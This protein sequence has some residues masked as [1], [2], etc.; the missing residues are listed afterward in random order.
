MLADNNTREKIIS[1]VIGTNL[2]EMELVKNCLLVLSLTK[3]SIYIHIYINI[4]SRNYLVY[5][6]NI[7]HPHYI[8]DN[9]LT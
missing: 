4:V 8:W 7:H 1:N 3:Y 6:N 5:L 2:E 9:K